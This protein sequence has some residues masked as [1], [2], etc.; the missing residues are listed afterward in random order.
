MAVQ[1]QEFY[2]TLAADIANV[3]CTGPAW[4]LL[5]ALPEPWEAPVLG[6]FS[7]PLPVITSNP[8]GALPR[9]HAAHSLAGCARADSQLQRERR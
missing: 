1:G 6:S 9:S 3:L 5:A 7:G 4:K 2:S 8:T